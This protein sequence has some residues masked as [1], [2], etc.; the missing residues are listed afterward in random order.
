MNILQKTETGNYNINKETEGGRPNKQTD[1]YRSRSG[2]RW[3][4]SRSDI[5]DGSTCSGG[6]ATY[7][8]RQ[9][10]Q[11]TPAWAR[12]MRRISPLQTTTR[13]INRKII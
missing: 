9:L 5:I 12:R 2:G 10:R 13:G 3:N 11:L 1:A 4:S 6:W 8:I 7:Q